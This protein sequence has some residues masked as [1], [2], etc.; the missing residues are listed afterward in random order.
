MERKIQKIIAVSLDDP[1][2]KDYM[3]I[4][5]LPTHIFDEIKNFFEIYKILENID[6]VD[7]EVEGAKEARKVIKEAIKLYEDGKI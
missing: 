6:V 2:N 5:D 1:F 4:K 7:K 3:D